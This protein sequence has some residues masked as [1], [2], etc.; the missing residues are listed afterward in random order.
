MAIKRIILVVAFTA[1]A[2][3][4]SA[5]AQFGGRSGDVV[6]YA[7]TYNGSGDFQAVLSNTTNSA[8]SL[9]SFHVT[10]LDSVPL[11]PS[12]PF[13]LIR[14]VL[15]MTDKETFQ[16]GTDYE[17][18][19]GLNRL[20]TVPVRILQ[21]EAGVIN[22]YGQVN[23]EANN[24]VRVPPG[25][26]WVDDIALEDFTVANWFPSPWP[27]IVLTD[28]P[29]PYPC[30]PGTSGFVCFAQIPGAITPV[31]TGVPWTRLSTAYPGVGWPEGIDQ[32]LL[33][34]D[35]ILGDTIRQ[36]RLRPGRET[37]PFRTAGHTHL[38]VLQGSVNITPANGGTTTMNKCD[39]AFLPEN[40]V[41]TL[42]NPAKDPME[43]SSTP[44]YRTCAAPKPF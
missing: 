1:L 2:L 41:V 13:P 4:P 23:A 25:I 9:S 26:N 22:I 7:I 29:G 27:F 8:D 30:P 43:Q 6:I 24:F 37:P 3:A 33:E 17:N 40:F 19:V 15:Y 12:P 20:F 38:F 18:T 10:V 44:P 34:A 32:K 21:L 16:I 28:R 31:A 35:P 39:Y 14:R 11:S 5:L 42:A 36:I